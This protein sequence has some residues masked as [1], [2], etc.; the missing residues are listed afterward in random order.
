LPDPEPARPLC[1]GGEAVVEAGVFVLGAEGEPWAYDN[2]RPAHE[3]ELPGF[4]IDRWPVSCG[5]YAAYVEATGAEPPQFWER[6]GDGWLRLRFGRREPLPL[7]E[8]VRH[9]SWHEADT[10]ARW[11]GKRLPSEAEWEKAAKLGLLEGTGALYEWT[12][13]PFR[14]YPGF[15]AFPYREYSE[16]FFGEGYRVLRGASWGT[17]PV[18]ARASFRNWDYP[19]RRQIF[20][21]LRCARD[22]K[23]A[24]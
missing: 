2:E 22:L 11:A 24:R 20:A 13:S 6:D 14:G 18:V 12:S 9:V 17:A 10:Y 3:V 8:P 21:G 15:R 4:A 7:E 19:I 16:V 5:D 1:A 23:E